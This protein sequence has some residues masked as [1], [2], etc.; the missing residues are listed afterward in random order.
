MATLTM[1]KLWAFDMKHLLLL[2]LMIPTAVFSQ[3]V[4]KTISLDGGKII[5]FEQP[6]EVMDARL[7]KVEKA[8]VCG[9]AFARGANYEYDLY[10]GLQAILYEEGKYF[11]DGEIVRTPEGKE[12][13]LIGVVK[14]EEGTIPVT[15]PCV[16]FVDK[17]K[18]KSTQISKSKESIPTDPGDTKIYELVDEMPSFPGGM[19][20]LM[21]WL[22]QNIKYPVIAAEN[23][24]QGRVIVQFVVEKDGSITDVKVA[25]SIDPSLD[26]EAARVVNSM[27]RWVPGKH[28]GLAVRVKYTVPVTFKLQ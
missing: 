15:F 22:A 23:R 13:R 10:N 25:Q 3:K 6:S 8:L 24:V 1:R 11:Y 20:A 7:Y 26:K 18:S 12:P 28:N 17:Q 9:V 2:L 19:G 27:P 21:S 16:A 14:Y 4:S 5:I